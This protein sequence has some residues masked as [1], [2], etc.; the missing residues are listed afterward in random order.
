[1]VIKKYAFISLILLTSM[2]QAFFRSED[3]C[4]NFYIGGDLGMGIFSISHQDGEI[5]DLDKREN[6]L[7]GLNYQSSHN[8]FIGGGRVGLAWTGSDCW[9][10]A[11]EGNIYSSNRCVLFSAGFD[12]DN[13][14]TG[15]V[16]K[17]TYLVQDKLSFIAGAHLHLGFKTCDDNALYAIVGYKYLKSNATYDFEF[18]NTSKTTAFGLDTPQFRCLNNNGWVVGLGSVHNVY[19]N[20]DIRLEALYTQFKSKCLVNSFSFYDGE[21]KGIQNAYY[22]PSLFYGVASLAY[23][24]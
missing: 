9:Y 19:C 8:V 10:A 5:V 16:S 2:L 13:I 21:V 18:E 15:K 20:W 3:S 1:M 22:R 12:A 4:F 23:N 11:I 7:L 17:G 24:F 14:S 6:I